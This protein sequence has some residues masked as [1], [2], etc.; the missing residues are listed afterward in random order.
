MNLPDYPRDRP[1]VR[2][3][4]AVFLCGLSIA[5]LNEMVS[6]TPWSPGVA[7]TAGLVPAEYHNQGADA[8]WLGNNSASGR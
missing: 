6:Y 5:G 7:A 1:Y 2:H 4:F 8:P 3:A